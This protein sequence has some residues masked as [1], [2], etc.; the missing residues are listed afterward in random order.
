VNIT[1]GFSVPYYNNY[2]FNIRNTCYN[3]YVIGEMRFD[4]YS[5]DRGRRTNDVS[6]LYRC[7]TN[8]IIKRYWDVGVKDPLGITIYPIKMFWNYWNFYIYKTPWYSK[9]KHN[10]WT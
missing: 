9:V 6:E 7:N 4:L 1:P 8:S 5:I 3:T 10:M 2:Q